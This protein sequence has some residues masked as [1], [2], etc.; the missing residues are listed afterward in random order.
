MSKIVACEIPQVSLLGQY[1]REGVYT[2]CYVT[3]IPHAVSQA[4][5][6]ECFYTTRLFKLERLLL[7]WF[8]N[9]PSADSDAHD[10]AYGV[11][12]KFA[13]WHVERRTADQLLLCDFQGR[14]R[15]WLMCVP[16][17]YSHATRLYFGS[18]VVPVVDSH[19]GEERM[20]L[21]FRLLLGFHK[22]YSHMLLRWAAAKLQR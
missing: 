1:Q 10:L 9:R 7:S 19:T 4:D 13:A 5:Y 8:V 6:I 22:L 20:G 2:D 16:D 17:E 11:N 12:D 3:E 21:L 14:T 18:A 15:S